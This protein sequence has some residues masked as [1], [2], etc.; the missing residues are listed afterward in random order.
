M[1]SMNDPKAPRS[2]QPLL[3]QLGK[4]CTDG[5][6]TAE[7]LWQVPKD[8]AARQKILD[9][10]TQIGTESVKQGREEMARLVEELE[11]A[12]QALPSPPQGEL[13]GGGFESMAQLLQAAQSGLP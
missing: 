4:M 3:D 5:K 12:A 13:F 1:C 6:E 11:I 9:L 8:A 10:L 7:Y 2:R